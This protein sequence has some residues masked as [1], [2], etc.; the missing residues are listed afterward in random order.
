MSTG[1][2]HR[3]GGWLGRKKRQNKDGKKWRKKRQNKDGEKWRDI[4]SQERE[5]VKEVGEKKKSG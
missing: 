5:K 3:V 2:G 1:H 4:G